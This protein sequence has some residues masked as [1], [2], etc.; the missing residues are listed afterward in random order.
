MAEKDVG[1]RRVR[2]YRSVSFK[3]LGSWNAKDFGE[4]GGTDLP[5]KG[6]VTQPTCQKTHRPP[7]RSLSLTRK[8]SKIS[9]A[10]KEQNVSQIRRISQ[11]F[12]PHPRDD[13]AQSDDES[14]RRADQL[15]K[16][17]HSGSGKSV[18]N[19]DSRRLDPSGRDGLAPSPPGM[20]RDSFN[21]RE[22][23]SS[24]ISLD[25]ISSYCSFLHQPANKELL[26]AE[27]SNWPSVTEMRKLFGENTRKLP[28][29]ASSLPDPEGQS[30]A[31]V[32]AATDSQRHCSLDATANKSFNDY[33]KDRPSSGTLHWSKNPLENAYCR[34]SAESKTDGR[35]L[36]TDTKDH[37]VIN[38][39]P[40]PQ[41]PP[42]PP[43]TCIPFG[44]RAHTLSSGLPKQEARQQSDSL[45]SWHSLGK[46]QT[47]PSNVRLKDS[48]SEDELHRNTFSLPVPGD[49][50]GNKVRPQEV[51][52]GSEEDPDNDVFRDSQRKRSVRKKK[53]D[54][55]YSIGN[56]RGHLEGDAE[57]DLDPGLLDFTRPKHDLRPTTNSSNTVNKSDKVLN[58]TSELYPIV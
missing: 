9:A 25:D 38:T 28:S 21:P 37:R 20:P 16:G 10:G 32:K 50:T 45:H 56:S 53:K 54:V 17:G 13:G 15:R 43:R 39:G 35:G 55:A 57:D 18:G 23:P 30:G 5:G 26:V 44:L 40:K 58:S 33:A 11:R 42:P 34:A 6:D 47:A 1:E 36:C 49:S 22:S 14:L 24:G 4:E 19:N 29:R 41:P 3:K 12:L 2:I 52:S 31:A 46:P 48:S 8:V 7:A 51:S 27:G